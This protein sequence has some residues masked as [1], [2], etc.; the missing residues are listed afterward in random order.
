MTNGLTWT[1]KSRIEK[2]S[3]KKRT[4]QKHVPQRTCV[5][6]RESLSKRELIRI[7]RRPEGIV[8]DST[9]K[10]PGRGAYLH[11]QRSCWERGMKGALE[12]ALKTDLTPEDLVRLAEYAASFPEESSRSPAEIGVG[13]QTM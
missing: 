5:G 10:M 4:R 12:R 1:S 3:A 13:S 11:K 6:C 2:V 7:V 9:G 8:I